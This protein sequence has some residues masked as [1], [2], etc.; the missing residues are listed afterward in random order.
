VSG[1]S[2]EPEQ[3]GTQVAIAP[4]SSGT[5]QLP[6]NAQIPV[7]SKDTL[8]PTATKSSCAPHLLSLWM[9]LVLFLASWCWQGERWTEG[10]RDAEEQTWPLGLFS[11]SPLC[12]STPSP[13]VGLS[14]VVN[15]GLLSTAPKLCIHSACFFWLNENI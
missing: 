4:D 5:S 14:W 9:I 1:S 8:D 11:Y 2:L 6:S 10:R 3:V 12:K 15:K 7:V 13:G